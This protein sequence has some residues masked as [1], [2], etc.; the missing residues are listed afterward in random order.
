MGLEIVQ[1]ICFSTHN[2]LT[3]TNRLVHIPKNHSDLRSFVRCIF[4]LV[5]YV[6]AP[7][8]RGVFGYEVR[9]DVYLAAVLLL[10]HWH[11]FRWQASC[12]NA[13]VFC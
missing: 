11:R 6:I 12:Y 2:N 10:L 9:L 3:L 7:S 5:Y 4:F 1:I 13:V 8:V